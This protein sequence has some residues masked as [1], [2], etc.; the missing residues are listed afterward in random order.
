MDAAGLGVYTQ[1]RGDYPTRLVVNDGYTD[2]LRTIGGDEGTTENE[3]SQETAKPTTEEKDK[4]NATEPDQSQLSQ[5]EG[6]SKEGK[7]DIDDV[8]AQESDEQSI[9]EGGTV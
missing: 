4:Q 8:V 2:F 3:M 5:V 7:K 1:G 9:V 6:E